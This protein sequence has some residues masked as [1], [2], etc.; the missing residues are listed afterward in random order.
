MPFLTEDDLLALNQEIETKKEKLETLEEDQEELNEQNI[1]LKKT[2][3]ILGIIAGVL[4][5]LLLTGVV[6]YFTLPELFVNKTSLEKK[7]QYILSAEDYNNAQDAIA[8]KENE[9]AI[10]AA[11]LEATT[12]TEASIEGTVIYAVQI[13]ALEDQRIDLYSNNLIQFSEFYEE[14]FYKYAIGAFETLEEA[15]QFRK[16]I[17]KLGFNDAFVASYKNGQRLKIEEPISF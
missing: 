16:E 3:L 10:K 17:V 13:K 12:T 11:E 9:E 15:Q 2:R 5:L 7:G 8:Y 1:T 4:G 14:E 6:L